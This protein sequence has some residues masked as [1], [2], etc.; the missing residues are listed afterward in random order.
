MLAA[1]VAVRRDRGG[2][3]EAVVVSPGD[4]EA[5]L[6]AADFP[7]AAVLVGAV[8]ADAAAQECRGGPQGVRRSGQE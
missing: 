6:V 7:F 8:R 1:A 2:K 3:R 5:P 4:E